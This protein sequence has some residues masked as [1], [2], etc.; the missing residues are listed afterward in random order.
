MRAY[1]S[2]PLGLF[3]LTLSQAPLS[4]VNTVLGHTASCPS[5]L[6]QTDLSDTP[7]TF[8]PLRE[9]GLRDSQSTIGVGPSVHTTITFQGL[10]TL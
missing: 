3:S 8:T 2:P 9:Q 6:C 5:Q 7:F 1:A 4:P 10:Q